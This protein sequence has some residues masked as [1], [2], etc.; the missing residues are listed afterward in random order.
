MT[1]V[2]RSQKILA[3]PMMFMQIEMSGISPQIGEMPNSL[4]KML[5]CVNLLKS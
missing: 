4:I 3:G 5:R 1:S 2:L